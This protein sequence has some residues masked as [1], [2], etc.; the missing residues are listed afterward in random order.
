VGIYVQSFA[1]LPSHPPDGGWP[2]RVTEITREWAEKRGLTGVL[3][4]F[5]SEDTAYVS[6]FPSCGTIAFK[7]VD[8]RISFDA[9]TSLVGPGFHA[10]LI[11]LCDA[12]AEA[13]PLRWRWDAGGDETGYASLRDRVALARAFVDQFEAFCDNYR[14]VAKDGNHPFLLNL[15][16]DVAFGAFT[17]VAT[18]MGPL[19]LEHFTENDP[20]LG[21]QRELA[22]FPWWD[23][24]L[25]ECFWQRFV[26][27][28][29]WAE[30]EWRA[31]RSPWER[32]VRDATLYAAKRTALSPE[33]A[34]A[35]AEFERLQAD[36]GFSA[37]SSEGIGWRRR[38][39]GYYLPGP[40]RLI[41][42]GYYIHQIEDDGSTTCVWFGNEEVR[43]SSMT[44]SPKTPG[45][46]S[47][48]KRFADAAEHDAGR[49]K[50]RLDT[51]VT[52]SRDHPGFGT[53]GAECQ[54]F[55]QQGQGHILLLSLFAP[56]T[57]ELPKRIEEVARSVFF[58]PPQA[59][60]TTPR[61]A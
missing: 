57:C 5:T 31:A 46:T 19:P 30:V 32:Y 11:A 51:N 61:D 18:P 41:M 37:P 43:G 14:R 1:E 12:I 28:M 60:P 36:E 58:D 21:E 55:D 17:G 2:E 25:D 42:P 8:G 39:R 33:L 47:W 54:A 40:W 22:I 49:F 52:P 34:S 56:T 27:T 10:A 38:D 20:L 26:Q 23:D 44:I 35:M 50:F 6:F 16:T 13:V 15:P 9:K 48:S 29:L 7:I 53:V 4:T 24:A 3:Y 45:E 59:L